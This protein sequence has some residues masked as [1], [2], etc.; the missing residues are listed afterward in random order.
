MTTSAPLRASIT[1]T[2]AAQSIRDRKAPRDGSGSNRGR[3]LLS[4]QM[5]TGIRDKG[6]WNGCNCNAVACVLFAIGSATA[7]QRGLGPLPLTPDT[8]SPALAARHHVL[9]RCQNPSAT[10]VATARN[11]AGC[12][13]TVRI[14]HSVSQL[15]TG[16]TIM[17]Q[18]VRSIG[19]E[20]VGRNM[21]CWRSFG[22]PFRHVM[23][24]CLHPC[25]RR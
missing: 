23:T 3:W 2:V 24:L 9:V 15:W 1:P 12:S 19:Q 20:Y 4:P 18:S 11:M 6:R 14:G 13:L 21:G 5:P 10:V 8:P 25:R 7:L 22:D 16:P 17:L